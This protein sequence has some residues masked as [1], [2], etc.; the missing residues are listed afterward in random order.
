MR[1]PLA[2]S[3]AILLLCVGA[4]RA[5]QI[6]VY[7]CVD[8]KGGISLQ[9]DPC[10]AGSQQS[11]R[12]MTRPTDAPPLPATPRAAPEPEAAPPAA[13]VDDGPYLIPPPPMYICTSYDGKTRESEV[14]DP[15][16]RCEPMVLYYPYPH[17]LTPEQART[18]RWVEDS[19]VRLSDAEACERFQR[20]QRE[21][22]SAARHAFSDTMAYRKSELARLTQIVSE[23]CP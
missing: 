22:V 13:P 9:D 10:P 23:S 8:A 15:N 19:C 12:S 3:L 11:E 17:R 16:P 1:V 5:E 21:A 14:Y 20:R 7:R 6:T 2:C 4:S 18:C